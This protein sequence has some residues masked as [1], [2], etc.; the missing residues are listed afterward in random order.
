MRRGTREERRSP[1]P[2]PSAGNSG[3][4]L[5]YKWKTASRA[6]TPLIPPRG[7][8]AD[9][10]FR[11]YPERAI[12]TRDISSSVWMSP[13]F[14][15]SPSSDP[16]IFRESPAG[17]LSCVRERN[18]GNFRRENRP[19]DIERDGGLHRP[20]RERRLR[21]T[22]TSKKT[23]NLVREHVSSPRVIQGVQKGWDQT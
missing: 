4:A 2:Q 14:Q 5:S 18:G 17:Y 6:R 7:S 22:G 15:R 16:E 19:R 21:E 11:C 13:F 20:G 12:Q 3:S 9:D 8:A 1:P 10:S 23:C